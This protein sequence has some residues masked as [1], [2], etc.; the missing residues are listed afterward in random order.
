[1]VGKIGMRI[2]F[3]S[4][5]I[6]IQV[7]VILFTYCDSN[8]CLYEISEFRIYVKRLLRYVIE[9]IPSIIIKKVKSISLNKVLKNAN[10]VK[11]VRKHSNALYLRNKH[12]IEDHK[13]KITGCIHYNKNV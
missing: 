3:L 11:F 2:N 12:N 5:G 8:L 13:V 1:M 4:Y 6:S 10:L 9:F 7:L